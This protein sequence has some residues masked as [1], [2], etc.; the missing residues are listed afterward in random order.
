LIGNLDK[1]ALSQGKE[2]IKDELESKLPYLIKE[3]G[4][5]PHTDHAASP[6]VSFE[7]FEY[8]CRL[9]KDYICQI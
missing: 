1:R 6:D 3:G 7:N 2:A 4:Y 9:V 8:Y 5:I